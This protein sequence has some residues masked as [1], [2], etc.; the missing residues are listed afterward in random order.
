MAAVNQGRALVEGAISGSQVL[1]GPWAAITIFLGAFMGYVGAMDARRNEAIIAARLAHFNGIKERAISLV[2][3]MLKSDADAQ[4]V[5]SDARA[6]ENEYGLLRKLNC[7]WMQANSPADYRRFCTSKEGEQEDIWNWTGTNACVPGAC[8][9]RNNISAYVRDMY[10]AHAIAL[11]AYQ[12][13]TGDDPRTPANE[14][15]STLVANIKKWTPVA[16]GAIFL[17]KLTLG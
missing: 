12:S 2:D 7:D 11:T 6:W 17:A 16:I 5:T 4:A 14:G 15:T 3:R 13:R 9:W 8:D 1:P 10:L